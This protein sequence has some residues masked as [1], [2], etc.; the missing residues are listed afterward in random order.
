MVR[1]NEVFSQAVANIIPGHPRPTLHL[2][3][4]R[5]MQI[6]GALYPSFKAGIVACLL[7][8]PRQMTSKQAILQHLKQ[9]EA[10]SLAAPGA[11]SHCLQRRTACNT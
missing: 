8:L 9:M 10:T 5:V 1:R 7:N 11:L 2:Y 4:L 6:T 3:S